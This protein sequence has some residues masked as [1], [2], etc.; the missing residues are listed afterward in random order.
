MFAGFHP[1]DVEVEGAVIRARVGG[2]GTPL[3]LLHGYPQTH[4]MWH[5]VAAQLARTHTVVATDLRGY[6]DSKAHNEDFTFRTMANDQV[7]VMDRLGFATFDVVAHDRGARTAHR[8]ALDHPRRVA[9]V[10]LL[11]I[12][13]TLDVWRLMDSWLALRY[14]HWLFLA[15]PGDMPRRMICHDPVLFLHAA[16]GGLGGPLDVFAPEALAAYEEAARNP[17]V[18]KAWCLDYTAAAGPDREHDEADR[19]RTIDVPALILWGTRGVVGAQ[20][21]PLDAWRAH[22]PRAIGR[23][24]DAGH[25]LVEERPDEVLAAVTEHL[26]GAA[27]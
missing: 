25:F 1:H 14:Y 6:G 4:A 18:V 24:I 9:S 20:C 27:R 21:D 12:L 7:R 5:P 26:D 3:L 10:A 11:D 13:P 16:L 2:D 22:F 17:E 19:G 23:S 15:Q 8:M